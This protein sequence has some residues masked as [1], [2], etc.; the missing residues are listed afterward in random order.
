MNRVTIPARTTILA[1][2]HELDR[3]AG[4]FTQRMHHRSPGASASRSGPRRKAVQP[5]LWI[6]LLGYGAV[7]CVRLAH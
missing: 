4:E 2:R 6:L 1:V 5:I 7:L 3:L